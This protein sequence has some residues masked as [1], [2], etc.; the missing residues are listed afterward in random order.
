[1]TARPATPRPRRPR[2]LRILALGAHPDD[3]E[4][5]AGGTG[6]LWA[7]AGHAVKFISVTNGNKGHHAMAPEPLAERRRA[8]T[9]ACAAILGIEAEVWDVP[10]G[11]LLA[12]LELRA[13]L[14]R[15][16]R[17]WRAD[18][19]LT[20]RPNDYHPDHRHLATAVQDASFLV[21]VPLFEPSVPALRQT[22]VFMFF[23]DPIREPVPFRPDVAV[24]IDRVA[25]RKSRALAAMDSQT[26]EWLPWLAGELKSVPSDR[27]GRLDFVDRFLGARD[28]AVAEYCRE[29][30][31]ETYGARRG[32][33]IRRAEAY[34]LAEW[35]ARPDAATLA[36]MF[37]LP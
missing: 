25:R 32:R 11:E 28:E 27:A 15:A 37:Q 16:I 36:A 2:A 19:V 1:M 22:P 6:R 29:R 20:H 3:C 24:A 23:H 10:D 4:I 7:A 30:L 8:E 13:R 9:A 12:T 5:H 35:G 33:A 17:Q 18:L 31:I 14:A 26:L 34:Q 21:R